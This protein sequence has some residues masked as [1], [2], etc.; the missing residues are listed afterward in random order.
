MARRNL[1]QKGRRPGPGQD[2]LDGTTAT[3]LS[4][5]Q[6]LGIVHY[7]MQLNTAAADRDSSMGALMIA[8]IARSDDARLI[9]LA[10]F[11]AP[12]LLT[13]IGECLTPVFCTRTSA[14]CTTPHIS[15]TACTSAVAAHQTQK[16]AIMSCSASQFIHAIL[17]VPRRAMHW[18]T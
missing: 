3:T 9:F 2:P 5:A 15:E 1:A 10:D 11:F 14:S 4:D 12:Q 6:W 7:L 13:D 18:S 16:T 8:C 17:Q